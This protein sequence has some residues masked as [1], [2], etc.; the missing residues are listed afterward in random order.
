[1]SFQED[2]SIFTDSDNPGVVSAT[3]AATTLNGVYDH[4]YIETTIGGIPIVGEHPVFG[5]AAADLPTF[6]FDAEIVIDGKTYK[7]KN[8]KP[9]GTGWIV[10][11]L[12][13][14]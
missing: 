13:Q 5:C 9:D 6:T 11:I 10:L 2:F 1:M 4:E 8:W 3:I 7:I 14:Q 12:E